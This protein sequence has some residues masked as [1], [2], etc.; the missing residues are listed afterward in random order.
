MLRRFTLVAAV[1][2]A[3]CSTTARMYPVEGPASVQAP[4]QVLHATINGVTG[5]NGSLTFALPGD[6]PCEGEWSSAAGVQT[7][8]GSGSLLSQYGPIYGSGYSI[9]A[10]GGQNPGRAIATCT[11][12][13]RF[14]M[15]FVTGGGTA[16]GFGFASDTRGNVYRVLF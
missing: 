1:V 3:G 12:G 15:E 4:V 9:A 11:D 13:T 2:L 8:F 14:E 5:N 6:I 16:N 10:G 7:T